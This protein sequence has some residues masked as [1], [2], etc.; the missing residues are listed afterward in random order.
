MK[1]VVGQ[2]S[3]LSTGRLALENTNAGETPGVAG[4]DACPTT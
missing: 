1:S 4:G 3:R 2:A